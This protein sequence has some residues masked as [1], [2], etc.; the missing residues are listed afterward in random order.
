MQTFF[1]ILSLVAI[2]YGGYKAYQGL[3][4]RNVSLGLG[5]L[6][7]ILFGDRQEGGA[8]VG[9]GVFWL[10]VALFWVG[11]LIAAIAGAFSE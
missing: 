4:E 6:G 8:A 3:V 5:P 2:A 9:V 1:I 10:I 7:H 11:M